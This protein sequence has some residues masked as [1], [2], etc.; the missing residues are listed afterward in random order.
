[1]VGAGRGQAGVGKAAQETTT[2]VRTSSLRSFLE[3][4]FPVLA[5]YQ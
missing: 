5:L 3:L 1:M 2:I 4:S